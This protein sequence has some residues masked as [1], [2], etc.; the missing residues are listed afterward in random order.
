MSLKPRWFCWHP[1]VLRMIMLRKLFFLM[2]AFLV[3]PLSGAQVLCNISCSLHANRTRGSVSSN[4]PQ[5]MHCHE[6]ED[7]NATSSLR[8]PNKPCHENNCA[9]TEIAAAIIFYRDS[10]NAALI[11][12]QA[13]D[14]VS[15]V[16]LVSAASERLNSADPSVPTVSLIPLRI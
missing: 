8:A 4:D 16:R 11:C 2:L 15:S 12:T 7:S 14:G 3:S 6:N 10:A 9:P 1:T 5:S 13:P